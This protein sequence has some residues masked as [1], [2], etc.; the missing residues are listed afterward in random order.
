MT[1]TQY[2]SYFS[3]IIYGFMLIPAVVLGLLGKKIKYY[4]VLFAFPAIVIMMG[5]HSSQIK[6]LAAF[7]IYELLL[8]TIYY[9]IHKKTQ[10]NIYYYLILACS[11][12]P[13]AFVKLS[14]HPVFQSWG[15]ISFAGFVGIS[16]ISFRIWQIIIE[17]HDNHVEK[18]RPVML[19]YFLTFAP[20]LSSG[21][22][23]RYHRF[24]EDADTAL[25]RNV[26][27]DQY[28]WFG[29][30]K[31]FLGSIYKFALA[32]LINSYIIEKLPNGVSPR[33]TIIYMYAYT[34]Y[35]F[36]DFAGYSNFAIGTGYILGIR[37]PENFDKPFLARNMKEFWDRWH[38][39][40]SKWFGDYIFSRFV[41]N[42][43]RSKKIKSKKIASRCG[44]MVTMTVMGLWHGTYLFYII[45]GL[46][47]GLMLLLT[48]V[49]IKSKLYRKIKKYR[50][51]DLVS[52]V[53]N[54]QFVAFGMLL[55]SGYLLKI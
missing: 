30:K 6:H 12:V 20:T 7:L 25:E 37:V 16:Y 32:A 19:F 53:V 42:T 11:I 21:P 14:V 35:L 22:I 2:G 55:F 51:Y 38:I 36:F 49:Y 4:G 26:Y 24:V 46:Y 44:Y 50:Y 3:L 23:D 41:L 10:K 13:I 31:I 9:Y 40:L 8:I 39:S 33:N 45:Y 54:F 52:R 29:L 15:V 47:E 18:L 17:I 48:D 5:L 43:L 28:L 1:I 34:L 27:F